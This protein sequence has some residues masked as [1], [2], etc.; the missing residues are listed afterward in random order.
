MQVS[1]EGF[2]EA[3]ADN[4]PWFLGVGWKL[5]NP[6]A[7]TEMKRTL[8]GCRGEAAAW[9]GAERADS[10]AGHPLTPRKVA[11]METSIPLHGLL[12][13]PLFQPG[14]SVCMGV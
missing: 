14:H 1:V 3:W 9:A 10:D 5:L 6:K 7:A 4:P 2:R 8:A 12:L 13:T 11:A